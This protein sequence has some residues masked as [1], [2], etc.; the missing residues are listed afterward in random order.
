MNFE[1]LASQIAN[2]DESLAQS[3][4]KAVN[5]L[6]TARNWLIGF[7]IVEY[8]HSG[9]DRATYGESLPKNWQSASANLVC[10]LAICGCSGNSISLIHKSDRRFS[11]SRRALI[12]CPL[13]IQ[14]PSIKK[15]TH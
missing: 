13:P 5:T 7:Y 10:L 15:C 12:C 2:L 3:A 8:E 14:I 1:A 4:S 6:L 11:I 9:Q